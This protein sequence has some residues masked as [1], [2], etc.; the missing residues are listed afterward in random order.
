MRNPPLEPGVLGNHQLPIVQN[1][2]VST[3]TD[4]LSHLDLDDGVEWFLLFALYLRV[5]A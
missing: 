3:D 1:C 5:Q 4:S 2:T